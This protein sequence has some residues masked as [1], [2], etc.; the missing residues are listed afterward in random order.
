MPAKTSRKTPPR[1]LASVLDFVR[2]AA[3]RFG[4]AKLAFGQG[5]RD[6]VED[7]M[8]LVCEALHL[9]KDNADA[10]LAARLTAAE[11]S[12]VFGLIEKRLRTRTPAAYLVKRVY[13]QDHAFTIDERAIVPRS[14]L[15]ELLYSDLFMGEE[16][17][18]DRMAVA[19]VL[20]LC[21]GSGCLAILACDVFPGA[22]IDAVDLSKD[23]LEVAKINVAE[24]GV[25]DRV[26]LLPGDLFKPVGDAVYDVILCN[27]PYVD[28]EGMARLP[29]EYAQEPRLALAAGADGLDI[30]RRVLGQ[31]R[32][33]LSEDG[34]LLCEIGRCRPALEASFPDTNFLWL[35]T[36]ATSGEVFW[37]PAAAL[38]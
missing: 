9:S 8:F 1:E 33:H 22:Q 18:V 4:A 27:P 34:G 2:Y 13:L 30:V 23:A 17:L 10:F 14:Y 16:Q 26:T 32:R 28:A 24:H 25:E 31:A 11:R 3:S 21:T 29:Q 38:E 37:L 5:T 6:A 35:D 7:A 20:D 36:A 19:R 15:A 12:R